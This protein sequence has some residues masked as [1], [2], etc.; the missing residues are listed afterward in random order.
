V[1]AGP[2]DAGLCGNCR[3]ARRIES[4]RGSAFLLCGRAATDPRYRR[5]PPLPVLQC[6]GHEPPTPDTSSDRGNAEQGL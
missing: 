1:S 4:A 6:P 3:H 2:V 5:Y